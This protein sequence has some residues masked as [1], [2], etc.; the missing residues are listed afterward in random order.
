LPWIDPQKYYIGKIFTENTLYRFLNT[1]V[2][3]VASS[4]R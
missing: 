2:S 4:S 3:Q 1:N